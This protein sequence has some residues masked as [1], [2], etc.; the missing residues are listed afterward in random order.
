MCIINFYVILLEKNEVFGFL[1]DALRHLKATCDEQSFFLPSE[2]WRTYTFNVENFRANQSRA[3]SFLEPSHRYIHRVISHIIFRRW[4]SNKKVIYF[5]LC[6][7]WYMEKN[8]QVNGGAFLLHHFIL[9]ANHKKDDIL[10]GGMITAIENHL[11]LTEF[12]TH[13]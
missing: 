4:T 12:R 8:I 2:V 6:V 13:Q 10:V 1:N 7:L 9:V 5:D 3:S 11:G